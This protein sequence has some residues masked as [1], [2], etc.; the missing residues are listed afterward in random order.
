MQGVSTTNQNSLSEPQ[1][2][3]CK[4]IH[5]LLPTIYP[6]SIPKSTAGKQ[7]IIS[8]NPHINDIITNPDIPTQKRFN[9]N[10]PQHKTS[11]PLFTKKHSKRKKFT[12]TNKFLLPNPTS[13]TKVCAL[14]KHGQV[15]EW[16]NEHAWKVCVQATVPRV[17]IPPCPPSIFRRNI[18]LMSIL[19]FL[20]A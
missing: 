1:S 5:P 16:S 19:R 13:Y 3:A 17:R 20:F 15:S 7:T 14:P 9:T 10:I 18:F 6:H 8:S 11:K 2:Y 12:P 4:M